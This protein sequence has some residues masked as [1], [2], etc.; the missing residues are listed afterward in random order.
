MDNL[1][2]DGAGV[3]LDL[4]QIA[5][6]VITGIEQV[7]LTGTGDNSLTL[8]PTDLLSLSD[9][10][11]TLTVIGDAGDSISTN[12]FGWTSQGEVA[13]GDTFF[14]SYAQGLATL[15]VDQDIDQT[16]ILS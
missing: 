1:R 13:V 4:S 3:G 8:A 7:D 2:I 11:N 12:D 15:L 16:G 10:S 14:N 6:D 5:D 9:T